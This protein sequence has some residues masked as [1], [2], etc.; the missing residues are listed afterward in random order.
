MLNLVIFGKEST[1]LS[2]AIQQLDFSSRFVKTA[3][4]D[5]LGKLAACAERFSK[6]KS[7]ADEA[8]ETLNRIWTLVHD[9]STS[10]DSSSVILSMDLFLNLVCCLDLSENVDRISRE[11]E[12]LSFSC[13]IGKIFSFSF[14]INH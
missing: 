11:L 14:H 10:R 2:Y 12:W 13:P 1:L 6:A 8:G 5:L 3:A 7:T 9:Y 4:L